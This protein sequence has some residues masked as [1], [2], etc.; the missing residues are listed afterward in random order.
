MNWHASRCAQRRRLGK[1]EILTF[2]PV[3]GIGYC[4]PL[5][6][7]AV[8]QELS[9]HLSGI[10]PVIDSFCRETGF[11][12]QISG[13]SRYAMRRLVLSRDVQ[14]WIELRML[15]DDNGQRF[16]K[17][18][19]DIPYWLGG[20][21]WVDLEGDRYAS[22]AVATFERISFKTLESQLSEGLRATWNSI[23][24]YTVERLVSLGPKV[25][26]NLH[27]KIEIIRGQEND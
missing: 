23:R 7:P 6:S 12:R 26:L 20:G 22:D 9:R 11:S 19:P 10:D 4:M 13:V 1:D 25:K 18:F 5:E 17:F 15:E 24:G 3:R 27:P 16:E 2:L 8:Y 14:W 21:A